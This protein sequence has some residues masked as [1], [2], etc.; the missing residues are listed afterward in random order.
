MSLIAYLPI[1]DDQVSAEN[2]YYIG[3]YFEMKQSIQ[4][5]KSKNLLFMSILMFY[6]KT[7]LSNINLWHLFK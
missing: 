7:F 6:E 3:I 2:N 1:N 4:S 5:I